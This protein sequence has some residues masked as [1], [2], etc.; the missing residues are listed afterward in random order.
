MKQKLLFWVGYLAGLILP[1]RK[2]WVK[3]AKHFLAEV[4]VMN[5]HAGIHLKAGAPHVFCMVGPPGGLKTSIA[6][7]IARECSAIWV[8]GNHLRNY[9]EE[10]RLGQGNVKY[11]MPILVG[12]LVEKYGRVVSDIN[13]QHPAKYGAFQA[14]VRKY[15]GSGVTFS[16]HSAKVSRSLL[17]KYLLLPFTDPKS[18]QIPPWYASVAYH[19]PEE[20][21]AVKG[22]LI[23]FAQQPGLDP[24]GVA[25]KFTRSSPIDKRAAALRLSEFLGQMHLFYH[26]NGEQRVLEGVQY[27]KY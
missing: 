8:D 13:H 18:V 14:V 15:S 2:K 5:Q 10:N 24:V 12:M 19:R 7:T 21:E 9:L 4:E 20:I 3:L 27:H 1:T 6:T 16:K 23:H 11:I 25:V 22:N 17:I 26:P